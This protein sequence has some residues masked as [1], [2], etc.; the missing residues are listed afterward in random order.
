M[1]RA[2]DAETQVAA[3]MPM[4]VAS[5]RNRNSCIGL[6]GRAIRGERLHATAAIDAVDGPGDRLR[7]AEAKHP[8]PAQMRRGGEQ[9]RR[10]RVLAVRQVTEAACADQRR[11]GPDRQRRARP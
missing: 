11:R 5:M 10:Q 1:S 8:E 4:S 9:A 7:I 2:A 6:R 3:S